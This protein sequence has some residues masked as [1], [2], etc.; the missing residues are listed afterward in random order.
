MKV[1]GHTT[2]VLQTVEYA[3]AISRDLLT[4]PL[5]I[6]PTTEYAYANVEE[7]PLLMLES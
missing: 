6:R 1:H 5:V 4:T 3:D 7:E 2:T